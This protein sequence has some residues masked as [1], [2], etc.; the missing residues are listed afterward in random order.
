MRHRRRQ[1]FARSK[2]GCQPGLGGCQTHGTPKTWWKRTGSI[3][4]QGVCNPITTA[5]ILVFAR[6]FC[7]RNSKYIVG[8][9]TGGSVL[10][11]REVEDI[12]PSHGG[13]ICEDRLRM[14]ETSTLARAST[15][16]LLLRDGFSQELTLQ[17]QA[18]HNPATKQVVNGV[19]G[20]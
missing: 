4:L 17:F 20:K 7:F 19:N 10:F 11:N 9:L 8:S 1:P 16:A 14:E 6:L 2:D 18:Q 15:L 12:L 3:E 5:A 13:T